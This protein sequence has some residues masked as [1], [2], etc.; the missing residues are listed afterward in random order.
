MNI[1][2]LLRDKIEEAINKDMIVSAVYKAIGEFDFE[3]IVEAS[4]SGIVES[5][6]ESYIEYQI[7][8]I[9]DE[10]VGDAVEDILAEVFC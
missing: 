2:E 6:V 9:I 5:K 7:D 4:I 8:G 10:T 1:A 3:P